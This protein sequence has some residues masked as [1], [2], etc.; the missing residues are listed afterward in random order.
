MAITGNLA[1]FSL[2]AVFQF[3]EHHQ[4]TGLLLIHPQSASS[5]Q[6]R[7]RKYIWLKKGQIVAV[8]DALDNRGLTSLIS[9]RGWLK[10]EEIRQMM[11]KC[12]C[13]SH[14]PIGLC[15]RH[16]G[17]LSSEQLKLLFYVSVL[18]RVCALFK[19]K[20]GQFVFD[21]TANLPREEMTGMSLSAAEAILWGLR[22]LRDWRSLAAEL[23]APNSV[24]TKAISGQPHLRLDSIER[25]VWQLVNGK[26]SVS[27]IAEYLHL[28]VTAVQQITCRLSLVGLLEE[29]VKA[30]VSQQRRRV[31]GA[32]CVTIVNEGKE[33]LGQ[34]RS[35]SHTNPRTLPEQLSGVKDTQEFRRL[36]I[37]YCSPLVGSF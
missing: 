20:E 25:Q 17:A 8:A 27:A 15:L 34:N 3:L 13:A 28:S 7:T 37:G 16:Q 31:A 19:L 24:L 32:E 2:P 22:V 35:R 10:F 14:T 36:E 1:E 12:S 5:V 23:P 4:G 30:P 33:I 18:L 6:E 9:Q 21:T 26:A 11:S 29:V